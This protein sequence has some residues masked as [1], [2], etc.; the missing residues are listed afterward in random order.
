MHVQ[1]N[2]RNINHRML[3]LQLDYARITSYDVGTYINDPYCIVIMPLFVH[4]S[5]NHNATLTPIM[6]LRD[7]EY[8]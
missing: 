1:C 3:L 8:H 5:P 6:T 4:V 7:Y 2:N